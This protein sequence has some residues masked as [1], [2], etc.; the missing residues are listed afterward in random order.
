[1]ARSDELGEVAGELARWQVRVLVLGEE[2][3]ATY[4]GLAVDML[5]SLAREMK[6]GEEAEEGDQS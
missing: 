1:M 2:T 4:V 3:P 5:V 6:K